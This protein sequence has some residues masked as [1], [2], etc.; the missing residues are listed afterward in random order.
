MGAFTPLVLWIVNVPRF[1]FAK[2]LV[3]SVVAGANTTPIVQLAPAFRVVRQVPAVVV[4]RRKS[5]AE[6]PDVDTANARLIPVSCGFPAGLVRVTICVVLIVP[7]VIRELVLPNVKEVGLTVTARPVPVSETLT[8]F[9]D[10]LIGNV[11]ALLPADV[12]LNCTLT[13]Q[14]VPGARSF[15]KLLPHV[16]VVS[17]TNWLAL[18]PVSGPI[19]VIDRVVVFGL[20]GFDIVTLWAEL[21]VP[22]D[23]L[24]KASD[25]GL[26]VK[27]MPDRLTGL[28]G[29]L[30]GDP[31]A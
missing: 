18:P 30:A 8:V 3:V 22:T 5:F 25:V 2:P 6:V 9:P 7:L 23:W 1:G 21:V 11:A 29:G 4:E 24:P 27:P 13:V 20:P 16:P 26:T 17:R 10:T 31:L 15:G 28:T 12:G 14:F 19:D